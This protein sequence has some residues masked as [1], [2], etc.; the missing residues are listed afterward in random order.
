MKIKENVTVYQCEHCKRK[1]FVKSA[2][3]RHE[4]WCDS[5]PDNAKAC[6]GCKHLEETRI[7]W[8]YDSYYYGTGTA[9]SKGVRCIKLDKLLYPLKAERKGL[10]DKYPETFEGQDPMPK[11][12]EHFRSELDFM[13]LDVVDCDFD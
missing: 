6:V 2:M 7:E 11:E 9:S 3:E 13:N 8:H 10:P 12:C 1:M 4:K 5:N